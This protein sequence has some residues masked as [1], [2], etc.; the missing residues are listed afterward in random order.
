LLQS[1]PALP[2]QQQ[3]SPKASIEGVVARMGSGEP[4]TGAEV[5][6]RRE[7]T[8]VPDATPT[9][10]PATTFQTSPS[11]SIPS[12]ASD[13]AGKFIFKDLDPGSYRIL[14]ARNGYV[15]QEFGQRVT[16][17]QGTVV[18]LGEG[19]AMKDVAFRLTP[20]GNVSG[21]VR[22]FA[23]EP[24]TGLRI[25]ILRSAYD[26]RGKRAL[27]AVGSTRTDDRGEY[28]LY[29]VTPGHYYL[30]VGLGNPDQ[31]SEGSSPNEVAAKPYPTTYYPGTLDP[32]KASVL[33]VQPGVELNAIDF[34]LTQQE[35]YRIR[36]TVID[37]RTGQPPRNVEISIAPRQPDASFGFSVFNRTYNPGNGMFE[38]RNVA[39]GSYWVHAT[40]VPDPDTPI[41]PNSAPRSVAELFVNLISSRPGAQAAVDVS[42]SDVENLVLTLT[43]GV[44]IHGRLSVDGQE[45]STL[46]GFDGIQVELMPTAPNE[47]VQLPRPMPPDGVFSLENALL[48]EYRVTVAY[49]QRDVYVK[50]A[51]FDSV[52]VLNQPLLISGPTSGTLNIVLSSKAGQIDGTLVNEQ[53]R[54]VPGAQAVLVPDQSRQRIELYKIAVTDQ[55][56]HFTIQGI[57]PGEYKIFAWEA[58]EQFAY[59]DSDFLRQSEQ[60]G[61][62]VNISESSKVTAQVKVIPAAQ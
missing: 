59:F 35:L 49:P 60:K 39:P 33:D 7:T 34:V 26:A 62:P 44:S 13:R 10:D 24:I 16:G 17:G 22:D 20:A 3:V 29:W 4:I 57:M 31:R 18:R 54:P 15:K 48:G 25:Q 42:G 37:T 8:A 41:A 40:T 51:R 55:N 46:T 9:A 47:D 11:T 61:T 50:E 32:S 56:G 19:Q 23:G 58:M 28:R 5:T 53:S 2:K 43:L 30:N 27:Q 21:H 1:L 52:D 36:G 6:L 12:A 45:L 38:F 14:A